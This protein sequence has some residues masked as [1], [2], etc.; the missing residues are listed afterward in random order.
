MGVMSSGI[1]LLMGIN[2]HWCDVELRLERF[3]LLY[4]AM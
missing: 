2:L 4:A 3:S 1:K